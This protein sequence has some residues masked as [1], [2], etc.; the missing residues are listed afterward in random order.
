[1]PI[2]AALIEFRRSSR[3]DF[4]S[5][6]SAAFVLV[7][8]VAPIIL[9]LAPPS[10]PAF[11]KFVW[12]RSLPAEDAPY[13]WAACLVSISYLSIAAGYLVGPDRRFFV[14]QREDDTRKYLVLG[15]VFMVIGLVSYCFYLEV[16]GGP[17][18][19]FKNVWELRKG[20]PDVGP[21]AQFAFVKR[22]A[23]FVI[24]GSVFLMQ[25]ASRKRG[26]FAWG[27]T[28]AATFLTLCIVV[29]FQGRLVLIAYVAPILLAMWVMRKSSTL[30]TK[31]LNVCS[32]VLI[33]GTI[34]AAGE[35]TRPM[36]VI[37][38]APGGPPPALGGPQDD[39][40]SAEV[41][42]SAQD[43]RRID[44][45][46]TRVHLP[47]P[48]ISLGLEFAF[49]IVNVL[50]TVQKVPGTVGY[51]WFAD[52][53]LPFLQLV[54]KRLVPLRDHLP[55]KLVE[56]NTRFQVGDVEWGIPVDLVSFGWYSLGVVGVVL[57]S[58]GF[59]WVAKNL[60]GVLPS[61]T[62]GDW[63]FRFSWLVILAALV[64][65]GDPYWFVIELFPWWVALLCYLAFIVMR[66][67]ESTADN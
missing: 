56:L 6:I 36:S 55:P 3:F 59:G 17:N 18:S 50:T 38:I 60:E 12:M 28:A 65:Y 42:P 34:F 10:A 61:S 15:L 11:S 54:P 45:L 9:F 37:V 1:M 26:A 14:W 67:F 39:Q 62:Y 24:P 57:T 66:P 41:R 35:M 33:F 22:L 58:F 19:A 5:A 31:L 47:N 29:F 13:V 52:L 21:L 27:L 48:V 16:V 25:F 49:P 46:K 32:T 2:L 30:R 51:R 7:F 8:F 4:L 63:V 23:F 44:R 40:L 53:V 20:T 64:M 43:A